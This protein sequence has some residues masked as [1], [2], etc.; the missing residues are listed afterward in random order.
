MTH[1][2]TNKSIVFMNPKIISYED[3]TN[4]IKAYIKSV[5]NRK[6]YISELAEELHI[7]MDLIIQVLKDIEKRHDQKRKQLMKGS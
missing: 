4:E 5:N 2:S 1:G 7:D 6:V 3:A